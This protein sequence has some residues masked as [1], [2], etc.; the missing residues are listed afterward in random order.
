MI[1]LTTSALWQ[2]FQHTTLTLQYSTWQNNISTDGSG[3]VGL[4]CMFECGT[5]KDVWKVPEDLQIFP[6]D[7]DFNIITSLSKG[8][9]WIAPFNLLEMLS[10]E[11]RVCF[12]PWWLLHQILT[13]FKVDVLNGHIDW[14]CENI[15][16][17]CRTT[18]KYLKH[19]ANHLK[20]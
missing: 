3:R 17:F 16:K 6:T 9:F 1:N 13:E 2:G 8:N 19:Y 12:R 18:I 10:H 5:I 20:M 15:V 14:Q 7:W 11:A 4:E